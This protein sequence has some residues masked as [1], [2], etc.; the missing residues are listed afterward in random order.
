MMRGV[1][2]SGSA[3]R[4]AGEEGADQRR[5]AR[6]DLVGLVRVDDERRQQADDGVLA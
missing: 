5:E 4:S 3:P 1:P 2:G 6:D